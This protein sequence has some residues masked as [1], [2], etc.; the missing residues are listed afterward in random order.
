MFHSCFDSVLVHDSAVNSNNVLKPWKTYKMSI[1][2][3][4]QNYLILRTLKKF[5]L[6]WE[7]FQ[8]EF[9]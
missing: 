8:L 6:T 2:L 1:I 7:D 4:F 3:L 5:S 9:C